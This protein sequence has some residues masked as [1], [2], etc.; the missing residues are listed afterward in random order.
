MGF[1][2]FYFLWVSVLGYLPT[3]LAERLAVVAHLVREGQAHLGVAVI[4]VQ[5]EPLELGC[6]GIDVISGLLQL[7]LAVDIHRD[8]AV[9]SPAVAGPDVGCAILVMADLTDL[10]EGAHASTLAV[11]ASIASLA[12]DDVSVLNS[13]LEPIILVVIISA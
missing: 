13:C 3:C 4:L 1:V 5:V 12:S 11:R 10:V 2:V 6:Q 7:I 9:I 8:R